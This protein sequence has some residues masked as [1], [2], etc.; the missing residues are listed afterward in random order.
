M[1]HI[2]IFVQLITSVTV[3]ANSILSGVV[4]DT[5]DRP[6]PYVNI[7]IPNTT[8]GTVSG[9]QGQFSL[10]I[11]ASVSGNVEV[12]FSAIG[13]LSRIIQVNC[14][15]SGSS[16]D[17]VIILRRRYYEIPP[18]EI[19]YK[20]FRIISKGNTNSKAR[21]QNNLAI[22]GQPDQNL[23]MALGRKFRLGNRKV[24]LSKLNFF[25][26]HNNFDTVIM[27]IN[28]HCVDAGKP[29][30]VVV[31]NTIIR[32]LNH[33]HEGWVQVD[34][35]P[36][37]IFL[38]GNIITTIEWIGCS[39]QGSVLTVPITVPSAGSIHYYRFGSQ[40]RWK[41]YPGMSVAMNLELMIPDVSGETG[42]P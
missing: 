42:D 2:L 12:M 36:Y 5:A 15:D 4:T 21:M 38:S 31:K 41:R 28:F 35:Q 37:N 16:K 19:T 11:D 3:Y 32:E 29:G 26:S 25:I 6:V 39:A 20:T 34:L 22:S 17:I 18:V 24:L 33:K 13:Y 1:K 40:N 7:G 23:G 14:A 8:T 10:V 30:D 9:E 27:R